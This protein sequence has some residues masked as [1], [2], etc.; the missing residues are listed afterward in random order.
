M[1]KVK[2]DFG[3]RVEKAVDHSGLKPAEIARRIALRCDR[4]VIGQNINAMYFANASVY[5]ADLAAVCGVSYLWLTRGVG[6]MINGDAPAPAAAPARAPNGVSADKAT[7]NRRDS[8][9]VAVLRQECGEDGMPTLVRELAKRPHIYRNAYVHQTGR[10][11]NNCSMLVIDDMAMMPTLNMR[12]EVLIDESECA[13]QTNQ[14]YALLTPGGLVCRRLLK[15]PGAQ[16]EAKSDNN[17]PQF[18]SE[19]YTEEEA[20]QMIVGRVVWRFGEL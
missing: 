20:A 19:A 12:D 14:I 15:R 8:D 18:V 4:R 11:P 13:I 2:T 9:Y 7:L 10:D 5:T 6:A 1:K 17:L 3:R 16:I